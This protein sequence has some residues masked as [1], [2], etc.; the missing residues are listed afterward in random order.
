MPLLLLQQL[1]RLLR[2]RLCSTFEQQQKQ[3][4]M[5]AANLRRQQ[6]CCAYE[7]MPKILT[8]FFW[9]LACVG[10]LTLLSC[11]WQGFQFGKLV[12]DDPDVRREVALAIA[13][14]APFLGKKNKD[15]IDPYSPSGD[16]MINHQKQKKVCKGTF[17][18]FV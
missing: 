6:R 18:A 7:K 3:V 4:C 17:L 10:L 2:R 11:I 8:L 14:F 15:K 9:L 16:I 13:N 12:Q 1:L 5:C